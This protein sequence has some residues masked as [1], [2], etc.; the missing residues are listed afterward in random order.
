MP[1]PHHALAA[2]FANLLDLT[3]RHAEPFQKALMR[4]RMADFKH[5]MPRLHLGVIQADFLKHGDPLI[6]INLSF[7]DYFFHLFLSRHGH[8]A[9]QAKL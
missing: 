5:S 1:P 3:R 6:Y 9:K 7:H 8:D 4:L 2:M